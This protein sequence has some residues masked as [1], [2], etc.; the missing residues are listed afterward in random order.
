M[1]VKTHVRAGSSKSGKSGDKKKKSSYYA[2]PP[3]PPVSRCVGY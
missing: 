2:P 1:K 3:K